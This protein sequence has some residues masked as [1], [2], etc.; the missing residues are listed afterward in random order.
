M[1]YRHIVGLALI[2]L[3]A[4][5]LFFVQPETHSTAA[6]SVLEGLVT[7]AIASIG[8]R[9]VR[10]SD[11]YRAAFL[12]PPKWIEE[13]G[14]HLTLLGLGLFFGSFA[15][16]AFVIFDGVMDVS[17]IVIMFTALLAGGIGL[18]V[19]RFYMWLMG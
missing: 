10:T 13:R 9:I 1:N 19:L 11:R 12:R 4:V 17:L 3:L 15:W 5:V 6:R 14:R 18:L 7:L 16:M 8:L 2:A